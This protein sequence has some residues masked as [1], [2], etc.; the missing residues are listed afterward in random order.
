MA[1]PKLALALALVLVLV[2]VLANLTEPVRGLQQCCG[3]SM[4]RARPNSELV[5]RSS[6]CFGTAS[7]QTPLSCSVTLQSEFA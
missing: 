7:P 3:R 5:T 4:I 2:L 1:T 6:N